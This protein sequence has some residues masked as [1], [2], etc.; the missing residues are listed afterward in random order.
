MSKKLWAI[1][2]IWTTIGFTLGLAFENTTMGKIGWLIGGIG[3]LCIGIGAMAENL[4]LKINFD[5]LKRQPILILFKVIKSLI[6]VGVVI[7]LVAIVEYYYGLN[8]RTGT[9]G[10]AVIM[11]TGLGAIWKPQKKIPSGK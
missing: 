10:G 4:G 2:V 5:T 6:V 3:G 9:M 11:L 8:E 1:I 7:G